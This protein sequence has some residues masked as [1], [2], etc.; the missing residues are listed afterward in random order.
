MAAAYTDSPFLIAPVNLNTVFSTFGGL[1][2]YL[3]TNVCDMYSDRVSYRPYTSKIPQVHKNATGWILASIVEHGKFVVHS[4][5]AGGQQSTDI[6]HVSEIKFA[7]N[8]ILKYIPIDKY[9]YFTPILDSKSSPNELIITANTPYNQL[10][11]LAS[12]H[13]G[14]TN[15]LYIWCEANDRGDII[16]WVPHPNSPTNHA[17]IVRCIVIVSYRGFLYLGILLF[18]KSIPTP[19]CNTKQA[20]D[21]GELTLSNY[22]HTATVQPTFVDTFTKLTSLQSIV[23]QF[24]PTINL[25]TQN[26][27]ICTQIICKAHSQYM[28]ACRPATDAF[29]QPV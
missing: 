27:D 26:I 8:R 10:H 13:A 5:G 14:A 21:M 1:V 4:A 25:T 15:T 18:N 16:Q 11:F 17:Q 29:I 20:F 6:V 9:S 2:T 23:S 7:T 28:D 19:K 3:D 22:Q 24:A 12:P